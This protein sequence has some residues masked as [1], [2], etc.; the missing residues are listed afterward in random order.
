MDHKIAGKKGGHPIAL[1]LD[2][3]IV[4][5]VC[6]EENIDRD[7]TRIADSQMEISDALIE[8]NEQ[9]QKA[10]KAHAME[11]YSEAVSKLALCINRNDEE[12]IRCLLGKINESLRLF[13]FN[14]THFYSAL[15]KFSIRDNYL[16]DFYNNPNNRLDHYKED[17]FAKKFIAYVFEI[18]NYEAT[19]PTDEETFSVIIQEFCPII[20]SFLTAEYTEYTKKVKDVISEISLLQFSNRTGI[21]IKMNL[22][23]DSFENEFELRKNK[24]NAGN[25]DY[26]VSEFKLY[27]VLD[28]KSQYKEKGRYKQ[29]VYDMNCSL[30]KLFERLMEEEV[31]VDS[32]EEFFEKNEL[33]YKNL[34]SKVTGI[35]MGENEVTIMGK[36][37]EII[38][39]S[40]EL[41]DYNAKLAQNGAVAQKV[42][43]ENK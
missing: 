10:L 38:T 18:N 11:V 42:K 14:K 6:F 40:N 37:L 23:P 5:K 30:E 16:Y 24:R 7:F 35:H 31:V 39:A 21:D 12:T 4:N 43:K 32:L 29:V 1:D 41:E 33:S 36:D 26:D 19:G 28:E 27:V 25:E 13:N 20:D 9:Y 17:F 34:G 8:R 22:S 3:T 2:G 15:E